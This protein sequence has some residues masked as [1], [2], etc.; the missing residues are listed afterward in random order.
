MEK[1]VGTLLLASNNRGKLAEIQSILSAADFSIQLVLPAHIR[2]SLDVD[3]TGSSY[4]ENAALK[5]AAFC[6]ASGMIAMADDSG[7]EVDALHGAPGLH[8]ARYS[9]IPG[10]SDAGRRAYLLSNLKGKPRPWKAHF[11]C[12]VAIAVP[13]GTMLFHEGQVYGEIMP[14]E[15]GTNGFGYDPIFYLPHLN[16]TMAELSMAEKNR[17]SHRARAVQAALPDLKAL[18]T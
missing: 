3:E 4:R 10:D 12:T 7:L 13:S 5:A 1:I 11:H 6:E 16:K 2:L 18:L 9:P 14:E 8:S 17:L 15:R